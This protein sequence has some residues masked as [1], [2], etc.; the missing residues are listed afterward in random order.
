M[1]K[2]GPYATR[3][4]T[5]DRKAYDVQY[6]K[7]NRAKILAQKRLYYLIKKGAKE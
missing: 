2:R 3:H 7:R 6:Y 1:K 4:V 5:R